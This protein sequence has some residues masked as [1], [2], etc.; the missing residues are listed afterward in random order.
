MEQFLDVS[1]PG[2]V[3]QVGGDGEVPARGDAAFQYRKPASGFLPRG[4]ARFAAVVHPRLDRRVRP[5]EPV[6][7]VGLRHAAMLEAVCQAFAERHVGNRNA[8]SS[9]A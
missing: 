1:G 4:A 8:A 5:G 3:R 7:Q 6:L 9:A 2:V